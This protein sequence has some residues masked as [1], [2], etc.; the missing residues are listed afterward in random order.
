MS[1]VELSRKVMRTTT[2]VAVALTV[3]LACGQAAWAD[4]ADGKTS[5]IERRVPIAE[6][7]ERDLHR[8]LTTAVQDGRVEDARR[9][10]RDYRPT[11]AD[12]ANRVDFVE[13]LIHEREGR[14]DEAART[15]R[16]ILDRNPEIVGV[17]VRL[18]KALFLANDDEAAKYQ[19]ERLVAS[20]VDQRLNGELGTLVDRIDARRPFRFKTY[21]S[22]LPSTNFNSGTDSQTVTL[23][24]IPLKID[25][26]ARRRSGIGVL[27]GGEASYRHALSSSTTLLTSLSAVD[28]FYPSI[29]RHYL[30]A[31]GSVGLAHVLGPRTKVGFS[32]LA[33]RD[34][35]AEDIQVWRRSYDYLGFNVEG[36]RILDDN[37][38]LSGG[39][40]TKR[41]WFVSNPLRD[42]WNVEGTAYL[43]KFLTPSRFVRAIAG[44]EIERTEIDRLN[45]GE[46][47]GG[48]GAFNEFSGGY[49][50]YAQGTVSQRLYGDDYPGLDDPRED[51]RLQFRTTAT[52]RDLTFM[53]VAPQVSYTF[54][55]N[56]SNSVFDRYDKHDVEVRLTSDF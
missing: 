9:M 25:E 46:V 2:S 12:H 48:V 51:T 39:V 27:F 16:V 24:G 32:L 17:R 31:G 36:S 37:F 40:V 43:D 11:D 38:R 1:L 44:A 18:S 50:L 4:A 5:R 10:V 20:G 55:H 23:G 15:Y 26:S 34:A 30:S 6:L 53:G 13:G 3:V 28:R 54:T 42:G 41:Q 7:S 47:T 22:A 8:L 14:Y 52:K 29:D 49:T 56:R 19:L 21:L 45:F 35:S 33:G